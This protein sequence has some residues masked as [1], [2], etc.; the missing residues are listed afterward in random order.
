MAT[1]LSIVI[2]NAVIQYKLLP[3][4]ELQIQNRQLKQRPLSAAQFETEC[5]GGDDVVWTAA[6]STF[7]LA[8]EGDNLWKK[9]ELQSG[10]SETQP[11]WSSLEGTDMTKTATANWGNVLCSRWFEQ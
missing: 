7:T 8:V 3:A 1:P 2:D 5:G 10:G 11:G 9:V 6:T 4:A